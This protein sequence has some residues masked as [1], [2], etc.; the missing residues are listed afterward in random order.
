MQIDIMNIVINLIGTVLVLFFVSSSE[1]SADHLM[2]V[3]GRIGGWNSV[4]K[5]LVTGMNDPAG[6]DLAAVLVEPPSGAPWMV[7][8]KSDGDQCRVHLSELGASK[9][10]GRALEKAVV[11]YE[12][13]NM[14]KR[15]AFSINKRFV[16]LLL[17]TRYQPNA[18][19]EAFQDGTHVVVGAAS[20]DRPF[21]YFSGHEIIERNPCA[22]WVHDLAL[23]LG[24]FVRGQV[25]ESE[26]EMLLQK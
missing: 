26:I 2:P 6:Y 12:S 18:G 9:S 1:L 24:R 20:R 5:H 25:Q 16:D 10:G 14:S 7:I 22:S 17:N 8:V 4:W 15:M 13:K 3:D 21:V 23:L 11:R 19:K